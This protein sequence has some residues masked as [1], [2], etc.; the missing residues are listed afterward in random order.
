M[1]SNLPQHTH[2][3]LPFHKIHHMY[4][5][6]N[7]FEYFCDHS[8]TMTENLA[9]QSSKYAFKIILLPDFPNHL[10]HP[11]S[12]YSLL[13]ISINIISI[14]FLAST[15]PV[16]PSYCIRLFSRKSPIL[17][18]TFNALPSWPYAMNYRSQEMFGII[19]ALPTGFS[20]YTLLQTR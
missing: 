15:H 18:I 19:F 12:S 14:E 2:I 13:K 11:I 1:L 7:L 16:S 17:E 10:F 9:L 3:F 4:C 20:Y 6:S 5:I 8:H